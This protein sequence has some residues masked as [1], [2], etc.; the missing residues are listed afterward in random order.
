M[1]CANAEGTNKIKP[2]VIG[3]A[4]KPRCFNNFENPLGYD[5]PESAWMTANIFRKWF[6]QSFVKEVWC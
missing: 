4:A 5:H 6:H 3:K 1:L 2:L